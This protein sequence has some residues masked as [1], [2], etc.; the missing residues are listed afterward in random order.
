M[1]QRIQTVYLLVATFL[2]AFF[3][4]AP[5]ATFVV[6][7]QMAKYLLLVSGVMPEGT[8]D[9]T[10]YSST[11][12]LILSVVVFAIAVGTIFLFKR[13]MAQIRLCIINTVLLLGMQG[14][15]YYYTVAVGRLLQADPRYSLIFIFPIV[16]AILSFLALRSVAKDEALVRSLERLR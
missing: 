8:P 15:L 10:I 5:F 12:L 14:L 3:F 11:P 13:R 7:P 6:E 4:F 16:S 1:I 2:L 9:D